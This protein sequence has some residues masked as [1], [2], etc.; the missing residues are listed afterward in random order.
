M[1]A[2]MFSNFANMVHGGQQVSPA[3]IEVV[4]CVEQWHRH[5]EKLEVASPQ[6]LSCEMFFYSWIRRLSALK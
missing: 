6:S 4:Y 3:Q 2:D 1:R 5:V